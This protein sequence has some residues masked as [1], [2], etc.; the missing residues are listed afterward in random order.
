MAESG[1]TR[2]WAIPM[3]NTHLR[4]YA[5]MARVKAHLPLL[6]FPH[7]R[8]TPRARGPVHSGGL[9]REFVMPAPRGR[10]VQPVAKH[11]LSKSRRVGAP[12]LSSYTRGSR[13][14]ALHFASDP[15]VR[16]IALQDL[17]D[18]RYAPSAC[19]GRQA[20]AELWHGVVL[21]AELDD[22][23]TPSA[24][25][26]SAVVAIL[27]AVGYRAKTQVADQAVL[28]ARLH[29]AILSPS[30]VIAL[31]DARQASQ[32][33]LGPSKQFSPTPVHHLGEL[34]VCRGAEHSQG[35]L[36]PARAL[37]IG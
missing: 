23:H 21:P 9:L 1:T 22:P 32:R 10:G 5:P 27:R 6:L 19:K 29:N 24:D 14:A 28:T 20:R 16:S 18:K 34:E 8:N 12:L 30:V 3:V 35:P 37:V 33:G 11:D 2:S 26:V 25:M 15:Q 36:R 17:E 7:G 4:S 31:K 13:D